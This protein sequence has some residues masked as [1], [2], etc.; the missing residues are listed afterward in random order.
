MHV[1]SSPLSLA[2][3]LHHCCA[4]HSC[5]IN[6]VWAFSGQTS[7]ITF[8]FITSLFTITKTQKPPKCPLT[9]EWIM[10]KVVCPYNDT[11]LSLKEERHPAI[12]YT[13]D[14]LGRHY[15][16]CRSSFE[17]T[18]TQSEQASMLVKPQ[19]CLVA[20]GHDSPPV[21]PAQQ[22]QHLGAC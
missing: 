6:N 10:R 8:M 21:A 14:T 11:L 16:K 7:Y 13:A 17:N 15:D 12:C 1:R 18:E 9:D 4:N 2:V 3:R 22:Q 5:Y 19:L 20:L